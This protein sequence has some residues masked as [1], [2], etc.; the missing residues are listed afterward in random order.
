MKKATRTHL[1]L[2]DITANFA[3]QNKL[4]YFKFEKSIEA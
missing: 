4:R 1:K 2:K 3:N